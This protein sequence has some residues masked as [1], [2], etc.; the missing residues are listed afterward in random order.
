MLTREI[1]YEDFDGN[2][3][4]ERFYFNL[5]KTEAVELEASFDGGYAAMAQRMVDDNDGA[6][7]LREV[8]NLILMAYGEKSADGKRFIKTEQMR[9]EFADSAAFDALFTEMATNDV[10]AAEF[11]IGILPKDLTKGL[12]A[13]TAV[14]AAQGGQVVNI[15]Q[16]QPIQHPSGQVP[17]QY[18]GPIG[19]QV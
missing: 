14:A 10:A 5:T 11:M 6:A 1:T 4:T 3:H 16:P 18:P 15:H 9:Q 12:D 2:V 13:P 8:K 7:I 19:Q 17:P